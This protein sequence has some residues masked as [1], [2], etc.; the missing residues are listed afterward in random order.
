MQPLL[1]MLQFRY[2]HVEKIDDFGRLLALAYQT[3]AAG[4]CSVALVAEPEFIDGL[5]R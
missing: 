5:R 3:L 2:H 1:A 4:Q